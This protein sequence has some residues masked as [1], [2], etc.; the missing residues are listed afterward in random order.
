V[1]AEGWYEW[2]VGWKMA[3][4]AAVL[5]VIALTVWAAV[6]DGVIG[7]PWGVLAGAVLTALA[8]V[9]AGFV[10]GI[11]DAVLRRRTEESA[12]LDA[13]RRAGELA[14]EGPAGLL[15]PRRGLVGF[16]GRDHELARLISW[17]QDDPA[18]RRVRLV[19]GSGGVGKTRLSVELCARLEPHG[20]R[21]VRA[22]EGEEAQVLAAARR[23]W[24]GQLLVV[25]DYAETRLGL[26][27]LLRAAAA[28]A[29]PGPVRVL[30]LARSAGEWRDRLGG[31]EPAVREL[32]AHAGGDEPLAAAVSEELSN[33][34][35]VDAAVPVFANELGMAAPSRVLVDVGAGA[36]RV[37]DL[38]AAALVAVLRSAGTGGPVRV[39]MA[40]VL[41]ELLAHEERFWQGTAGRL[42]FL[43]GPAGMSAAML[44]QVVAAGALLGAES[45][46]QTVELLGRVPGAVT[47][48]P[49]ASWLRDLYPPDDG[50]EWLGSLRPDR[51]A[52][53]LVV[54]QLAASAELA[55]RCLAGLDERQALRAITLLGRAA[56]D[57]QEAAGTLLERVLPLLEQVVAE[58]PPD[59][60]LL[61][62]I[63]DAIPYPSAA[64]A[65]ANLA[66]TRRI[67]QILPD[68]DPGLRALWLSWLAVTLAQTGR[69]DQ[70]LPPAQEAVEIR[71]EL[72]ASYPDRYRPDLAGSLSNLGNRFSELG[73]P[74]QALPPAREAVEIR[75]ELAAS[76]PDRYR[77]DLADSLSNLGIQFSELGRPDQ[78][79][80][81]EQEAVEAW[82]ELAAAYPDRYLPNLATS[83]SNLGVTF[84]ELGRP[85]EALPAEQEAVEI[86]RELA[87]SYPDRYRP[88]LTSSLSNLGVRFAELGHPDQ[89]LPPAQEAVE[90]RRELAAAYPDRYRP[91]LAGSLSNLGNLLAE[92]GHPDQ[93][94][95][96]AQEAVDAWRE[97]AADYPDR[98]RPNLADSLSNLG[99][100]FSKL[101][102]P[103]EA[104]PPTQEAVEIRRELAAD[105]PD[106]YRSDL[107]DS[108][109]NLGVRFAELGRPAEALPAEQEAVEIRRELAVGYPD[110]YRPDLAGS[111]SNLGVTFAE[112][113][114]PD[115][116]L[117]PAQE[118]VEIRREL[119]AGYPDRYRLELAS[120]LQI[121]ALAL[122]GLG[123]TEEAEAARRDAD[124][125]QWPNDAA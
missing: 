30:L 5:A 79:L 9:A 24:P 83:L 93:A 1:V 47:S 44:R 52:E 98:Y 13:L 122:D 2:G 28:D 106:R 90:I 94:L 105:Y 58:L 88:D 116:A 76:Y 12:D 63:S 40:D 54:A 14:G 60:G 109:S 42:G 36:V 85:A 124:L 65:E 82:R 6:A 8:G 114:R 22:G 87:A 55:G 91:N 107:A 70:A 15:D 41:D 27:G 101:G 37:L 34:D 67:L 117:P 35:L 118:A 61:T 125:E 64:L 19:T 121:L 3:T 21:C 111:L 59:L 45:Q 77:P 48:V 26:A 92:L 115:Q 50:A 62:A 113:G 18:P 38:H 33:Q 71:R 25:V 11:R 120:S 80:S 20:W 110:R 32:L 66:V 102:R 123:R 119:A 51:L 78:A 56:A 4:L 68:S 74:D 97:L 112:L 73:R 75:R 7:G 104:L 89:A 23:G 96:P 108:L 99:V 53:H 57:Q 10:P 17:C 49:V 100:T 39:R 84:S 95:P 86:R 29:G 16:T 46:E 81:V 103:A 43:G 69:P 72:A 31:G